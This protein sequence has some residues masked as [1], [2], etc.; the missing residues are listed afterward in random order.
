MNS[1][2]GTSVNPSPTDSDLKSLSKNS[3]FHFLSSVVLVFLIFVTSSCSIIRV[4][5]EDFSREFYPPKKSAEEVVFLED[6]SRPHTKIAIIT[7]N[8]ERHQPLEDILPKIKYEA[9][10]LGGDAV[11]NLR[12]DATGVWKRLPAQK[13]LGN[14]YVRANYM[15]DVVVFE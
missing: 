10:M 7:V 9:A 3:I 4:D 15:A 2:N 8:T 12:T 5:S 13:L 1:S 11:T 14:A 6:I